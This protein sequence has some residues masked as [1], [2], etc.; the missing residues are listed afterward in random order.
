MFGFISS[1]LSHSQFLFIYLFKKKIKK[2]LINFADP[3]DN[4]AAQKLLLAVSFVANNYNI[5]QIS[6]LENL[7][8]I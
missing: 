8:F 1:C 2:K 6:D 4:M 7:E 3:S 5:N